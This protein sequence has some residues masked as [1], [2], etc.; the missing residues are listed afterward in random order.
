SSRLSNAVARHV[1][2]RRRQRPPSGSTLHDA[3]HSPVTQT[4]RLLRRL[5]LDQ[6]RQ[7]S[8]KHCA[9]ALPRSL[10]LVVRS[11]RAATRPPDRTLQGPRSTN[12]TS[13]AAPQHSTR[14]AQIPI[15]ASPPLDPHPLARRTTTRLRGFLPWRFSERQPSLQCALHRPSWTRAGIRKPSQKE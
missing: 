12:A 14:C 5:A 11:P 9:R 4:C 10:I 3:A 15:A 7:R 13:R 2:V 6:L 8:V 1:T